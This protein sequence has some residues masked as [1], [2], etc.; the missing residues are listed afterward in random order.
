MKRKITASLPILALTAAFALT[1]AV[2]VTA[3]PGP[4]PGGA[5][6][7][8]GR[9]TGPLAG[10]RPTTAML[11]MLS[12]RLDLTDEQKEKIAPILENTR[13]ELRKTAEG[14][15]AVLEKSK[16]DI[17]AV[18]NAEQKGKLKKVKENIGG[19][20]GG[21]ARQH[22]PEIRERIHDAGQEIALRAALG[23]LDDLTDEQRGKLK[24]L[25]ERVNKQREAIQA[26]LKPKMEELKKQVKA[27][28]DSTLTDEQKATLKER[29]EKMKDAGTGRGPGRGPGGPHRPGAG[30]RVDGDDEQRGNDDL[31]QVAGELQQLMDN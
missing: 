23:S 10:D 14:T 12:N 15:K 16:E 6:R 28:L 26:E 7:Q 27:E 2:T 13:K 18:L 19:A 30:R 1:V 29:M 5:D 22:G 31:A 24:E 17:A 20:V 9:R 4:G 8:F 21:F 11:E 3:G 25:Q